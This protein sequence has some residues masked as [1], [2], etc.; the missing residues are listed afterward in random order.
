MT[1]KLRAPFVWTP[2]QPIDPMGFRKHYLGAAA[3]P[4]EKNRWFLFRKTARLDAAPTTAPFSITVDGRYVLFANGEEIGRGPVRCSPLFQRYDDYDLAAHLRAGENA[5][6][7]LVHTYGRDT[8][9]YE[10]VKGLWQPTFG[11]GGLWT[12]GEARTAAGAVSLST[13]DGWRCIR[14][15][16]WAQDTPQ[17]NHS[18]GFIEDLDARRLPQGWTEAGFDDSDWEEARPLVAGGGGP[19]APYGGMETRPFPVLLPRGIPML[20]TRKTAARR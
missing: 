12:E 16:A 11:D 8:A 6:A 18:L 14:S 7:V 15:E 13:R 4:N 20:E 9:F 5:L 2:S 17:S 19:E 1:A 3:R 10:T